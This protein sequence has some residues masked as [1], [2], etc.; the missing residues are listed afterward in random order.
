MRRIGSSLLL[1]LTV[2]LPAASAD[3]KKLPEAYSL[4]DVSVFRE[5]GLALPDAKLTLIPN[6]APDQ[7][8]LKMKKL[9]AVSNERGEF[10]FRVPAAPM[11]YDVKVAARGFNHDQKT[12]SIQGEERVDVTF[13]LHEESK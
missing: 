11:R 7:A 8:P 5:P 3:K 6:P 9:E 1:V 10:V 2:V 12:V 13:L 4:V